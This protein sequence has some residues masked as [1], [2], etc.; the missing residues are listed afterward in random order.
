M[1]VVFA[2][3]YGQLIFNGDVY[4][5]TYDP[6]AFRIYPIANA[7]GTYFTSSLANIPIGAQEWEGATFDL[8]LLPTSGSGNM[9]G[10]IV[11]RFI[12]TTGATWTW[13]NGPNLT[14][15]A[16]SNYGGTSGQTCPA[17]AD[18]TAA[19]PLRGNFSGQGQTYGIQPASNNYQIAWMSTNTSVKS[20]GDTIFKNAPTVQVSPNI[21][22]PGATASITIGLTGKTENFYSAIG[23][24]RLYFQSS[25]SGVPISHFNFVLEFLGSAVGNGGYG[26]GGTPATNVNIDF[27][28][29][30]IYPA[31]P[32]WEQVNAQGQFLYL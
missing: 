11:F 12:N 4:V 27:R 15:V 9:T 20:L 31:G 25:V 17:G 19:I 6:N 29:S 10:N 24:F 7:D 13:R 14:S 26:G 16:I 5:S 1:G 18:Q 8:I 3:S 21:I 30:P 32:P 2:S 28:N 23:W 22:A